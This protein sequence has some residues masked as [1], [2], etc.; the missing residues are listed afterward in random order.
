MALVYAQ[1]A[2][3]GKY[4]LETQY[5]GTRGVWEWWA[6]TIKPRDGNEFNG[7]AKSLEN[8]MHDSAASIGLAVKPDWTPI[9][10][11]IEIAD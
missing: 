3:A 8:A 11:T 10:P 1:H 7:E 5:D 2:T 6:R 4:H 9:G